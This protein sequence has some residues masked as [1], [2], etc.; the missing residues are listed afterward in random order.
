[1]SKKAQHEPPA[2]DWAGLAQNLFGIN[3]DKPGVDDDLLDEDMFKVEI[4]PP[5]E[6]AAPKVAAESVSFTEAAPV[7]AAEVLASAPAE[8]PKLVVA[9]PKATPSNK[10]IVAKVDLEEDPFGAGILEEV[11]A[12]TPEAE[13]FDEGLTLPEDFD[14]EG[15]TLASDFDDGLTL[16]PDQE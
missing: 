7:R 3:L 10:P 15:L 6:P 9:K 2:D 13:S 16:P 8:V 11:V 4:P 1:M 5:A 14:E 12:A